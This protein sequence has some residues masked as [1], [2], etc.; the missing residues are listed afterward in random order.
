KEVILAQ[1]FLQSKGR[2]HTFSY[3]NIAR[4]IREDNLGSS[5]ISPT[6]NL[7]ESFEYLDGSPGVL[8]TRTPDDADYIYYD[9]IQDVFANKDG[10]LYGTVMLPGT[11]FK[12]LPVN[13][14]AGVKVWN[15]ATNSY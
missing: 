15:A 1:D 3:D 8:K 2:T 6:L 14:Q 11:T 13:L 10:R 4:G 12:G 9:N 7:V 5:A